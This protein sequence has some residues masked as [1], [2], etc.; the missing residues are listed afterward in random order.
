MQGG[1]EMICVYILGCG[2][3]AEFDQQKANTV[4]KKI[5]ETISKIDPNRQKDFSIITVAS[6]INLINCDNNQNPI[7]IIEGPDNDPIVEALWGEL[8]RKQ[9]KCSRI[10]K[11]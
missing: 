7:I 5:Q 9:L 8:N 2:I 10:A 1:V 4:E 3:N 11:K 6:K